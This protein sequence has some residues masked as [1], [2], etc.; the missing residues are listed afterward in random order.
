MSDHIDS[1]RR[2]VRSAAESTEKSHVREQLESI[3]QGL[4]ALSG[5]DAPEESAVQGDRLEEI[6][7]KLVGLDET[8]DDRTT[9]H[10][11]SARDHL[12]AYRRE[13]ARDW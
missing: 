5:T 4:E 13:F 9:A 8:V 7:S 12:D 3:D 1:A 6:E 2:A 10:L 11:E